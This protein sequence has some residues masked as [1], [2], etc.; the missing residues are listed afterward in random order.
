MGGGVTWALVERVPELVAGV[1]GLAAAYP[2][3]LAPRSEVLR[4]DGE[5][6]EVAFADTGVRFVVD[7]RRAYR[8]DDA[9]VRGQAIAT[10]TRFPAG[11]EAALR[12]GFVGLS[13]R[14][15]LQRLGVLDGLPVVRRTEAFAGLPVR[16]VAGGEDPAHTRAIEERTA[17]QL[18]A[19]GA[20]A[21]LVF[22]P[23][24][25]IAGNGHFLFL[26]TNRD[27]VLA[28]VEGLVGELTEAVRA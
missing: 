15:L 14:L 6:A 28:V 9:Y 5:V 1:V 11:G 12:A 25:G 8:Y 26:E 20:D 7:R 4:D 22:L 21:R 23:D 27:E 2:G 19:W 18:R 16:L 24:L 17:A 13:P 10:S 3:N